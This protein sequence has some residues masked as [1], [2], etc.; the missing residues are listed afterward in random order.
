MSPNESY[1]II[2]VLE[3]SEGTAVADCTAPRARAR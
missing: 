1:A 2:A 3:H